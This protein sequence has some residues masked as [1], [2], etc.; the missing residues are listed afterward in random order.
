MHILIADD[1]VLFAE[2]L[3]ILFRRSFGQDILINSVENA[4]D[5][6]SYVR[7]YPD[8]DLLLLDFRM[9]GMNGLD[10]LKK[11]VEKAPDL[12]IAL[13]SGLAEDEDI[14]KALELGALAYLPK[15]LSKSSLLSSIKLVL[16]GHKFAPLSPNNSDK[17]YFPSYKSDDIQPEA[18]PLS[19][20][21]EDIQ[22]K[23]ENLSRR[24]RDVLHELLRGASNQDIADQYD[25]QVSTVKIHVRN[26]CQKMD[27][28]NRTQA[29]LMAQSINF[30]A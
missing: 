20:R 12:K 9:P 17:K 28:K 19:E 5:A 4:H 26:I 15:T 29:A 7:E 14:E 10:G 23:I 25:L 2:T 11:I 1:H 8:I 3:E 21:Y 30:N 13:M 6:F 27:V 22:Q 16:Q 24:E 18:S